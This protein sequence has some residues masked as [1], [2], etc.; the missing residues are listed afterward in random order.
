MTTDRLLSPALKDSL[1]GCLRNRPEI[2]FAILYGSAAEGRTF[3][4][5]DIA[6]WV[7][8]A[9]LP[10]SNELDYAF[11]LA[12]ELE[13]AVTHRVD[14]RVI[15]DA[16]LAFRYNVSRGIPLLVNDK[17]AFTRFL[18]RTWDE[19]LD[20]QPLAMQYLKDLA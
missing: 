17:A 16:P 15:N 3:R 13:S 7:E 10:A 14:V 8:R 5:L 2:K 4:D 6:V 11:A 1:T 12:D 18:E 20:F 9:R 19:F